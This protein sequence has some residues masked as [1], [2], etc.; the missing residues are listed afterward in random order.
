MNVLFLLIEYLIIKNNCLEIPFESK[1]TLTSKLSLSELYD[2]NLYTK[3]EIGN[4]NQK[5]E[6]PIKLNKYLT[7]ITSSQ[8]TNLTCLKFNEN[9]SL[10]YERLEKEIF[11]SKD[12]DFISGYKSKDNIKLG[13]Q[14]IKNFKFYLS[15]YQKINESGTLGLKVQPIYE[16]SIKVKE[17]GIINQLKKE[18]IIS[19]YNYYIKFE[20][21]NKLGEYKGKII[22]GML[23][24]ENEPKLFKGLNYVNSSISDNIINTTWKIYINCYYDNKTFYQQSYGIISSSFGLIIAPYT[25]KKKFDDIFFFKYNCDEEFNGEFYYF[26]CNDNIEN[27]KDLFIESIFKGIN[28]TLNYKDLFYKIDNKYYFLILFKED[29]FIWEF[30]LVFLYKYTLV[31]NSESK[32]IGT[33]YPSFDEKK[34]DN[35]VIYIILIIYFL[36]II[37]IIIFIFY[38]LSLKKRRLRA[39]ELDDQYDYFSKIN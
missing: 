13:N 35:I 2:I 19:S 37:L 1:R 12:D 8:N 32:T 33:Y 34:N 9:S 26:Y 38:L 28:F 5:L 39:N 27:F 23:P 20:K 7:Y 22:I 18:N 21:T 3:I 15:N 10:T 4:N 31:F 17:I 36:V 29:I 24:H 14:Q 25:L 30:G 16:E 11:N 6:I